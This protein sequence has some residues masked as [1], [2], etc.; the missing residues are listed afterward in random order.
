MPSTAKGPAGTEETVRLAREAAARHGVR[1]VVVASNTGETAL[2]FAGMAKEGFRV[3]CVGHAFGFA[4]PGQNEMTPD[5]RKA[6]AEAGI[7][8]VHAAHV[9]SGAERGI[10]KKFGGRGP[11]EIMASTLYLFGQGTKVCVEIAAM[12]LDAGLVP[13]GEDVLAVGGTGR[14]ADTACIIRPAYTAD[15]LATRVREI[16]CKPCDC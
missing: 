10:S 6:L 12:A 2:L 7:K 11:V 3:V 5:A 14:G 8:V 1:N 15:I 16:V 4:G 9:L 13:F